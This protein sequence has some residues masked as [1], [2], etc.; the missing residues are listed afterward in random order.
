MRQFFAILT[1]MMITVLSAKAETSEKFDKALEMF[2]PNEVVVEGKTAFIVLPHRRITDDIYASV[3]SSGIC[4]RQLI[5]PNILDGLKEVAVLNQFSEQGFV[6]EGGTA[7]C[8]EL[9]E[10]P[11]GRDKTIRL[12]GYTRIH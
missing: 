10:M 5:E 1:M 12:L 3:I 2:G 8:S 11:T 6:F 4:F 7:E 9:N